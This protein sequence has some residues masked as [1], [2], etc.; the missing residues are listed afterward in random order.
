MSETTGTKTIGLLLIAVVAI[1][2]MAGVAAAE[3]DFGVTVDDAGNEPTVTVTENDSTVENATVNVTT[4]EGQNVTYAGEGEYTTDEN[5]TVGLPAA[6]GNVTVEV[7]AT[8][9]N[10]SVSTTVDL[11][12]GDDDESAE[13][14]PFG[15]LVREF[16]Q[17]TDDRDGGIG[18]AVSEFVTS[19]N[20]GNADDAPGNAGDTPG[21]S[22]RAN[23]GERG[24]PAHAGPGDDA[25]DES[26]DADEEE[27][28]TDTDDAD[29]ESDD[30]DDGDVDEDDAD[31]EDESE[32]DESEDDDADEENESE[33][34]D[35]DDA[36]DEADADDADDEADE[37]DEDDTDDESEED[38]DDGERGPPDHAGGP[39]GN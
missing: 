13:D 27:D 39:G 36:D 35:A 18:S 34:A 16:I 32:E 6:E 1:G 30:A 33:E 3:G 7:T 9:E 20:P 21:N 31:D 11:T 24:P 12:T 29:E 2:A 37:E 8:A 14:T 17:Q 26:D 28:E 5:G 38:D 10:E 22:D 19:N 25:D 23:D 15:Q 4:A